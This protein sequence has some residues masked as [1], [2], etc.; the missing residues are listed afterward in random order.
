[1][2]LGKKSSGP[3]CPAGQSYA[4]KKPLSLI[5]RVPGPRRAVTPRDA[6]PSSDPAG[7]STPG[8]SRPFAGEH[9][10]GGCF[11][12]E[13]PLHQRAYRLSSPQ[14]CFHPT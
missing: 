8:T 6:L 11:W 7:S 12:K 10:A 3:C 1:M 13:N 14:T 4:F 2:L 9:G 5:I